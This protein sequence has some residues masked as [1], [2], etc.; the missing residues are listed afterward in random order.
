MRETGNGKSL[1]AKKKR[2]MRTI[3]DRVVDRIKE[4]KKVTV[5]ELSESLALDRG[6]VE[7]LADILEESGLITVKYS[8]LQPGKTELISKEEAKIP[9][10]KVEREEDLKEL[11]EETMGRLSESEKKFL[12]V[13]NEIIIKLKQVE[14]NMARIEHGDEFASRETIEFLVKEAVEI[15]Q[16]AKEFE[17]YVKKFDRKLEKFKKRIAAFKAHAKNAGKVTFGD[18]VKFHVNRVFKIL[19]RR[20]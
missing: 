16:T 5:D 10:E 9:K 2:E 8:L 12:M 6:Q 14:D 3:I 18:R 1:D 17:L 4:K 13:E 7:K 20:R 19:F 11:A 15:E